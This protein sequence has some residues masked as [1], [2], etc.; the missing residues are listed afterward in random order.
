MMS[1]VLG[2]A[3]DSH[4]LCSRLCLMTAWSCLTPR[5]EVS[6]LTSAQTP[7]HSAICRKLRSRQLTLGWRARRRLRLRRGC[8]RHHRQATVLPGGEKLPCQVVGKLHDVR[9]ILIV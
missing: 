5:H 7:L 4:G 8:S 1:V 2:A 9:L 3:V 6:L